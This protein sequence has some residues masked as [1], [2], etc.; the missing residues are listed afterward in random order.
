MRKDDKFHL[1]LLYLIF[2]GN[3]EKKEMKKKYLSFGVKTNIVLLRFNIIMLL[4]VYIQLYSQFPT[5]ST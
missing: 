5:S 2:D 3:T 1:R 4:F